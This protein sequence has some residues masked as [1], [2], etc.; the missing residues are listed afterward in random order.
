MHTLH[1]DETHRLIDAGVR[2]YGSPTDGRVAVPSMSRKEAVS[3]PG[4]RV[5]RTM[6]GHEDAPEMR[7]R[8]TRRSSLRRTDQATLWE[9][10][11][12]A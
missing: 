5:D 11:A 9:R 3:V 10:W 4:W 1:L 6:H 7:R 12:G 2:A 8:T